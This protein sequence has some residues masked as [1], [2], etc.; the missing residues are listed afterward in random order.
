[1]EAP[2]QAVPDFPQQLP[3]GG[4]LRFLP[5]LRSSEPPSLRPK[6][7]RL[8]VL[9]PTPGPG[10]TPTAPVSSVR[11]KEEGARGLWL[12]LAGR[13]GPQGACPGAGCP[14][15]GGGRLRR[16]P[17][18][19]RAG[20]SQPRRCAPREHLWP[21]RRGAASPALHTRPPARPAWPAGRL[22]QADPLQILLSPRLLSS[23]RRR[24]RDPQRLHRTRGSPA[25]LQAQHTRPYFCWSP[26]E[27]LAI[28]SCFKLPS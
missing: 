2:P 12:G 28:N 16:P 22:P 6:V 11:K 21:G 25:P 10:W 13:D 9:P 4:L 7:T 17:L 3:T 20:K 18:A 5:R 23:P 26:R 19:V 14:P 27:K 1:M 8:G 15:S 24:G